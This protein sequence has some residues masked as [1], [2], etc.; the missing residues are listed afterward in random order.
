MKILGISGSLR[1]DSYNTQLLNAASSLLGKNANLEVFD[2]AEIPLYNSDLDGENKPESVQALINAITDADGILI[3]TPEYNYSISGVLKN[4]LDWV[5]RPAYN[6]VMRDK[7]TGVLS[8]SMSK[9]GGIRA[10]VHLRDIMVATLTPVY[11]APDFALASA[12]TAFDSSGQLVDETTQ[13]ILHQFLTGYMKWISD[14][15]S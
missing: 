15:S 5:S 2:L 7:P 9:L 13:D 11:L 1:K 12:H 10:Q 14:L 6:S 4:A 8:T 3:A